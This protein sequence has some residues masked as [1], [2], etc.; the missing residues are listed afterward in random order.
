V[1]WNISGAT[2]NVTFNGAAPTGGNIP[3]TRSGSVAR[4]FPTAG[5]FGYQCTRHGGMTGQV[6]V[7]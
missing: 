2:H 1:T 6:V 3:D 5:T 4:T 7:Q